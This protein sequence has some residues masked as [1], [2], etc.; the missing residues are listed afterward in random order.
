M[1]QVSTIQTVT[2]LRPRD[3]A[4][5][6]LALI[7]RTVAADCDDTEFNLFMEVSRRVGLDPFRRQIYAVVYSKDTPAKR[8]MSI[9][10][11]IDGFRAVAARGQDYR[12]DEA[13]P[14][15]AYDES[16]KNPQNNPL[17]IVKAIVRCFKFGPD[18]QWHP[19]VGVAYWD[20][21][22]PL[23]EG[24][25]WEDTG[26]TWPNGNPKKRFVGNGI[27]TLA[28]DSKW[29]TMGR[30]MLPKCAESQAIRKGWP[31]DLS[32]IYAPEELARADVI[33]VTATEIISLHEE[34]ER[35]KLV[36]AK[37]AIAIWWKAGDPLELVPFGQLTDRACAFF[38]AATCDTE[39][40][41]WARTNSA[42]LKHFWAVAKADA[43][44]LKAAMEKRLKELEP[45]KA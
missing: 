12:P 1:N 8:K 22:A 36:H 39:I 30:V 35:L 10:T 6:Q 17:G 4:P 45:A 38:K 14:E 20:E 18:K 32:G 41:V 34:E 11:G 16:L 24:G 37:D 29:R 31:E 43:Y 42:S 33:D 9:I 23:K 21:F 15:I 25:S 26:E 28:H 40:Q 19:V 5:A 3:Y 2:P 44:G 27:F 13:E 7:K